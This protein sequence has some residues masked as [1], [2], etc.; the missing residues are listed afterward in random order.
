MLLVGVGLVRVLLVQGLRPKQGTALRRCGAPCMPDRRTSC[1][2]K[3]TGASIGT[4][5]S[6]LAPAL[7]GRACTYLCRFCG[8]T[9]ACRP[10]LDCAAERPSAAWQLC[11]VLS[12]TAERITASGGP[13]CAPGSGMRSFCTERLPRAVLCAWRKVG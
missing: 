10:R 2:S 4:C 6:S 5:S 12:R 8:R 13:P 3:Q 11:A 7:S 1:S 9:E